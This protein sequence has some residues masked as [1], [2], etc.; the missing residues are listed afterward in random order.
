MS[1]YTDV[2]TAAFGT[3]GGWV[4]FFFNAWIVLGVPVLYTVL[5]GSNLNQLCKGTVAEIGH[6]PWT[7]ICCAIVAIPYIIIKSM[8]EVAWMSAFGALATIVVVLIVLICAAIDRPNH[9][10][11]HHEPFWW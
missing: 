10:D 11:A 9:M 7:I 2:A 6:V 4:T 8:K 1:V 3:I 5:A